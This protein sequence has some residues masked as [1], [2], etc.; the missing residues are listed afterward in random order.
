MSQSVNVSGAKSQNRENRTAAHTHIRTLGLRSDGYAERN[1]G[2]FIGQTAAREVRCA[3]AKLHNSRLN[4]FSTIHN[5][6]AGPFP[7]KIL[8]RGL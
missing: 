6:M 3:V 7:G 8:T 1:G 2:G 4:L 5:I